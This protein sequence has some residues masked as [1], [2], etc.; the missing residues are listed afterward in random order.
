MGGLDCSGLPLSSCSLQFP[1]QENSNHYVT[2]SVSPNSTD[3]SRSTTVQFA[4]S[5]DLQGCQLSRSSA[6]ALLVN[7]INTSLLCGEPN[8]RPVKIL[9]QSWSPEEG[10]SLQ[11]GQTVSLLL[12]RRRDR[13]G[14]SQF[15]RT[16][17]GGGGGNAS[18]SVSSPLVLSPLRHTVLQFST[19]QSDSGG[20]LAV[21]IALVRSG[22]LPASI[23]VSACL[24]RG[25]RARPEVNSTTGQVT[26][27]L[28]R[29]VRQQG[30]L[31]SSPVYEQVLV[32][33]PPPGT[34]YLSLLL[35]CP[36][37]A[38]HCS[39]P[40]LFS[41]HTDPCVS[42]VCGRY[43]ECHSYLSSSVLYSACS[44]TAGHRGLAC[45]DPSQALS[46]YQLLISSL[47]LTTSNLAMLPAIMLAAYRGHY[48]EC[49]VF[50]AHLIAGCL[51]HA[52][53]EQVYSVCVL[54]LSV[55]AWA[56]TFTTITTIW[57]TI[58]T[59]PRL[60]VTLRSLINMMAVICLAVVVEHT[61]SIT[62]TTIIPTLVSL[63]ILL[64]SLAVR[65]VQTGECC[66]T[67][68]Y[69]ALHFIPGVLLLA[70]SIASSAIGQQRGKL[71]P[72][73]YLRI[74]RMTE[75]V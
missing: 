6:G 49:I 14:G 21:E 32:L 41:V 72:S 54:S 63:V 60:P 25:Y 30:R 23:S 26:C 75:F 4:I 34:W 17:G 40:V 48:T 8:L 67:T 73:E 5:V 1:A 64:V 20:S 38:S 29:L 69:A 68:S 36:G 52:C 11:C 9:F 24:S 33:Y 28:G 55:L 22:D 15:V 2:V 65:C 12:A 57:V 70:A 51:Y 59:I 44:C 31:G 39:A 10:S 53:A 47:L 7:S 46:D 27:G 16:G 42:G 43:G 58:L 62:L 13:R 71:Q 66:P 50:T 74:T 3:S 19:D 56:D 35:T 18:V 61:D 45:N 37:P